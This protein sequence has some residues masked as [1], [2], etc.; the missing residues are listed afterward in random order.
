MRPRDYQGFPPGVE[1]KS[2]VGGKTGCLGI[3]G[4]EHGGYRLS[5]VLYYSLVNPG[6]FLKSKCAE[7]GIKSPLPLTDP[8]DA[9]AQRML[10]I[11]YLNT[12]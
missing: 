8:R 9:E 3:G 1:F 5:E 10:N 7:Q 11:P 12:D 4:P 2:L 6:I